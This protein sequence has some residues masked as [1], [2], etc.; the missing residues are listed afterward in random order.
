[1]SKTTTTLETLRAHPAVAEIIIESEFDRSIY[2]INLRPGFATDNG[3]GQ[4]SGSERTLRGVAAFLRGV[5][6]VKAERAA[7]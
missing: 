7:E 1:M 2:W 4:Q 6:A 5:A 3:A